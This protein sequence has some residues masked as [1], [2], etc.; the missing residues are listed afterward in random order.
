MVPW[1]FNMKFPLGTQFTFGSLTFVAGE[2][3]NL[4][5]LPPGTTSEH[6]AHA[7]SSTSGSTCSGSDPFVG[8]YIRTARLIRGIQI[9]TSTLRPF[10]GASSSS[11]SALSPDRGSSSDYPKIRASACGNSAEDGRLILMVTPDGDRARNSSSGYPTIGRSEATD[12]QTPSA[13]LVQNL[14]PDFNAVR[15]H[16][17]METIQRMAPNGSPLSLLA[18]QGA[19]AANFVVAEKSAGVPRGEPSIGR[20]DRA[21][22]ARSE[23]ASLASP[24][25][26]LSE[27]V[28]G[29]RITQNRNARKYGRNRND[30]RNVI[31]DRRRIQDRTPSLP[32]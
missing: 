26:H 5:M 14:N 3:E 18:Q 11:S 8:L 9:V 4:K 2:D 27:H 6:P 30:L 12:A 25:R 10:V 16:T 22:R 31:E 1:S 28:A 29:R 15:V 20:N 19:E 23:A 7:P 24:R 17:I 13:G 32:P 21:G